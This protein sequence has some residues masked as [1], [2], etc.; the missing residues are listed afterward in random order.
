MKGAHRLQRKKV[1][2]RDIA[3]GYLAIWKTGYARLFLIPG[4]KFSLCL[5]FAPW[6]S[7]LSSLP[8]SP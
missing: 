3:T 7:S 5:F 2:R 8:R 1:T 4:A 6:C